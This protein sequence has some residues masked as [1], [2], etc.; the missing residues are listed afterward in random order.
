MIGSL[1]AIPIGRVLSNGVGVAFLEAPLRYIFSVNGTIGWLFGILILA[2]L[3]SI[4]P[5][6]NASRMSVQQ[7]LAYE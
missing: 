1:A 4:L 7:S 2:T 3:A 6:W 5:A